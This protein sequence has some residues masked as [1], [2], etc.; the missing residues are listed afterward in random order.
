MQSTGGFFNFQGENAVSQALQYIKVDFS[1]DQ[2]KSLVLP[3]VIKCNYQATN[4]TIVEEGGKNVTIY[5][6]P[7]NM[8]VY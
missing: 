3:D 6:D 7:F 1:T 2:K 8:Q 5:K 4:G